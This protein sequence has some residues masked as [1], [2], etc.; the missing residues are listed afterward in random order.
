MDILV[1]LKT[2]MRTDRSACAAC[3]IASNTE[4]AAAEAAPA[5][6]RQQ[7]RPAA[8]SSSGSSKRACTSSMP[9]NASVG[10]PSSWG[11]STATADGPSLRAFGSGASVITLLSR[12]GDSGLPLLGAAPL[13]VTAV[14]AA[15]GA[16]VS[17]AAAIAR[18]DVGAGCWKLKRCWRSEGRLPPAAPVHR[19]SHRLASPPAAQR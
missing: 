15:A 9:A 10:R 4:A 3:A 6:R 12:C 1:M 14:A 11:S 16:G 5:G 7:H 17:G 13:A 8:G 19:G 2:E 18:S